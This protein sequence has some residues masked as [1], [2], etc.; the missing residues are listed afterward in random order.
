MSAMAPIEPTRMPELMSRERS[1]LDALLDTVVL[2]HIAFVD[3]DGS[4]AVI[5]T[6]AARWGD[7]LVVHG[8]TGSRWMRRVAEGTPV[9]VSIAA[10]DGIVVA[11]SAFESSLIYTSAVLFGSFVALEGDDKSAGLDAVTERL[12]PGR[13]AEVRPSTKRELAATMLL[14]LPIAEWSLRISDDWSED[15]EDDVAGPAWAG[16]LRF[17]AVAVEAVPAPN[18]SAGIPLPPS[19]AAIRGVR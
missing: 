1:A 7:R 13:I 6:A 18:L 19:S 11:R 15:P 8:S 9:A 16:Q 10:I 14:A 5:P 2:A 3:E 4:P 12:L 17:G